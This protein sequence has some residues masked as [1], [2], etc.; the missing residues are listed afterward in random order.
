M[1][2]HRPV[3]ADPKDGGLTPK[4]RGRA[5]RRIACAV[6]VVVLFV[7]TVQFVAEP[8]KVDSESMAPTYHTGDQVMVLKLGARNEHP[9][10]RDVIAFHPPG[11]DEL[12]VKRVVAVGG[13][14]VGI[15]DGVLVVDGHQVK[16]GFVDHAQMDSVYFGPVRVPAGS[17]FMMGDNRPNSV[18]SRRFGPVPLHDVVG[19]VV[20]RLWPL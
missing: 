17:V 13:D 1:T 16:E 5:A 6:V 4:R 11:S 3:D 10:I 20:A 9:Q 18:D 7:L 14:T 19:R 12:L 15:E 8:M 2:H